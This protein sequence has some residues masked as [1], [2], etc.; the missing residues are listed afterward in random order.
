M[1]KANILCY[2]C[3]GSG[4]YWDEDSWGSVVEWPCKVCNSTGRITVAELQDHTKFVADQAERLR[5]EK[6]RKELAEELAEEL[7]VENPSMT[8]DKAHLFYEAFGIM[9][10]RLRSN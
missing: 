7:L 4:T 8:Y 5:K 2:E 9:M 10:Q 3:N 6:E 1:T